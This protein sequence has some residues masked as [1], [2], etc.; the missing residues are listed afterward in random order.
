MMGVRTG[1]LSVWSLQ[2]QQRSPN[3]RGVEKPHQKLS[4]DLPGSLFLLSGSA[5]PMT[6]GDGGLAP[7]M[8]GGDGGSAPLMG[9][10]DSF[11]M[12]MMN[13]V[14]QWN[15][16]C[17]VHRCREPRRLCWTSISL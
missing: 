4:A 15:I 1:E 3:V 8:M 7:L 16:W 12:L 13:T 5:S 9:R 11:Q 10:D 6:G 17:F 14:S 2:P